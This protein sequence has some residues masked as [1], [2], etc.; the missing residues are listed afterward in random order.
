MARGGPVEKGRLHTSLIGR[1]RGRLYL[2]LGE[3]DLSMPLSPVSLWGSGNS[4]P[5]QAEIAP[6]R[7]RQEPLLLADEPRHSKPGGNVEPRQPAHDPAGDT[8]E[9][10]T[11]V[12][13]GS[14]SEQRVDLVV[15]RPLER[16]VDA[17]AGPD[18]GKVA[19]GDSADRAQKGR[20]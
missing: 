10:T 5:S 13:R 17:A 11:N 4:A 7:L 18:V 16:Q 8:R 14:V 19:D 6:G 15:G 2:A 9:R 3:P 12:E 1:L 20:R